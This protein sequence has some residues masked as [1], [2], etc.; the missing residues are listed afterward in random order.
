MDRHFKCHCSGRVQ[1]VRQATGVEQKSINYSLHSVLVSQ[2]SQV[3]SA[4]TDSSTEFD[5]FDIPM[6]GIQDLNEL[7]EYLSQPIENVCDPITWWWE[8][9]HV[10]PRLSAMALDYLSIPGKHPM[11]I[12]HYFILTKSR[13]HLYSCR[14]GFLSRS[15]T[16]SF[17]P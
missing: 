16:P 1:E 17:H 8:H 3:S 6:D 4:T 11:S 2:S 9:R 10:Y 14:T 15:P 12:Y 5:F 13:S 7:D